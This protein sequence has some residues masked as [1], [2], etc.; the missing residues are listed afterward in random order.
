MNR[1][2]IVL[3]K[4]L[5]EKEYSGFAALAK[6]PETSPLYDKAQADYYQHQ[7]DKVKEAHKALIEEF[8]EVLH[9][10]EPLNKKDQ[11]IW[12]VTI[13]GERVDTPLRT[14]SQ[15]RSQA[16]RIAERSD[17]WYGINVESF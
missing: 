4:G 15:A 16:H 17:D 5:L 9:S 11:K 1:D 13:D 10:D 8:A 3:I 14:Y 7:V 6:R 12:G 2:Q